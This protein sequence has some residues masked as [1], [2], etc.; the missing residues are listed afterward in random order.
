MPSR[1]ARAAL[2]GRGVK[3]AQSTPFSTTSI[4][5]VGTP[6]AAAAPAE[7]ADTAS[8][9]SAAPR[10]AIWAARY[11]AGSPAGCTHGASRLLPCAWTVTAAGEAAWSAGTQGPRP[12][13]QRWMTSG[14]SARRASS[15]ISRSPHRSI[16]RA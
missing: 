13:L 8:T 12:A 15:V 11:A 10:P 16:P 9:A 4:L 14:A 2:A 5:A 3:R 7:N 1:A 6:C